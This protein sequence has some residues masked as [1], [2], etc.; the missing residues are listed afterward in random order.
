M[1]K[2]SRL[3]PACVLGLALLSVAT[4]DAQN[5]RTIRVPEGNG[6]PILVDGVFTPG[7]WDD[8]LKLEVRPGIQLLLK[9]AAGFVFIGL[10]YTP[11]SLAVVDLFVSPDGKTIRHLHVS[12]QLGERLAGTATQ[13]QDGPQFVWGD[14]T[15]WYANEIRWNE[16]KVRSLVAE[17]KDQGAAQAAAVY[18]YDGFEF[19][20]RQSKFGRG[21]W[22]VRLES[23]VAPDW[24]KPLVYP[25]GT[26]L[27]STRGWLSL[28]FD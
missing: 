4:P 27:S 17:G 11:F 9:K 14:T 15:D 6:K 8:A 22:L 23:P 5:T 18:R 3:V 1:A 2:M 28:V 19:Q 13:S 20:I 10:K 21:P 24:S 16:A 26:T 7:E 12:A 25:E